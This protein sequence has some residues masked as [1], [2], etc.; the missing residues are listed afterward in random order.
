MKMNLYEYNV[1]PNLENRNE[2][3]IKLEDSKITYNDKVI[4]DDN[5]ID[6]VYEILDEFKQ[7]LV[8][9][10]EIEHTNFKGGRQRRLKV[11]YD[12][13]EINLIGNTDNNEIANFYNEFKE[14]ILNVINN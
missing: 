1:T 14:K 6:N 8:K 2:L 5:I 9:Y 10:S 11:T 7:D 3:L 13:V 12:D 4:S